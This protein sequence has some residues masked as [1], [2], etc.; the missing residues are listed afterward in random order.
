M[1]IQDDIDRT[2]AYARSLG[3]SFRFPKQTR[4]NDRA[5]EICF[6][7]KRIT[8]W[9]KATASKKAVLVSILHELGHLKTYLEDH[10]AFDQYFR[11]LNMDHPNQDQR[12]HIYERER[13]D[14][15]RMTEICTQLNLG[16]SLDYVRANRDLD[17]WQYWMWWKIGRYPYRAEKK[18]K[19]IELMG[20]YSLKY[21]LK[22]H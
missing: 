11:V 22:G 7:D 2:I 20:T 3:I 13:L 1:A 17:T 21:P 16:I 10:R 8:V 9:M 14:T 12:Y 4:K 18:A 19:Q 6:R 5:A 15:A